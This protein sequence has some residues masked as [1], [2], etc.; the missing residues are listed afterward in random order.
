MP[1]IPGFSARPASQPD[2]H[3]LHY[4]GLRGLAGAII[5]VVA[6]ELSQVY[7][8]SNVPM[9]I[10]W[11][12]DGIATG[13]TLA[14]GPRILVPIG[15]AILLW[16]IFR[17]MSIAQ[18]LLGCGALMLAL[19]LTWSLVQRARRHD[20]GTGSPIAA[21]VRYHCLTVLPTAAILSL[22]GSWQFT[23]QPSSQSAPDIILVMAV[24]EILGILLF[25]RLSELSAQAAESLLA[26]ANKAKSWYRWRRQAARPAKRLAWLAGLFV[27]IFLLVHAAQPSADFWRMVAS[28]RYL[29]FILIAWA[30]YQGRPFFVHLMTVLS[31]II[32]IALTPEDI[33]DNAWLLPDLALLLGSVAFLGFMASSTMEH[34][35]KIEDSL[36]EAVRRD[37]LTGWLNEQGLVAALTRLPRSGYLVGIDLQTLRHTMELI[38]LLPT[39][40]IEKDLAA[41][42]QHDLRQATAFARP[43][44]GFFVIILPEHE[45]AY[46][47]LPRLGTLLNRRHRHGAYNVRIQASVSLLPLAGLPAQEAV[48]DMLATLMLSCQ[49]AAFRQEH[50]LTYDA[51]SLSE[52][53]DLDDMVRARRD[54]L[55]LLEEL[56]EALQHPPGGPKA[57]GLWLACQ[58]IHPVREHAHAPSVEILLRWTLQDGSLL[59]PDKFLPLAER[60]GLMQ[61]LDRWVVT[62]TISIVSAFPQALATL[63]KV[64]INLSGSSLSNP[65]LFDFVKRALDARGLRPSLFCFEITETASIVQRT[66]AI[67][68]LN[69]LRELGI[70]TSLDD[71]GTGLASFDYL[72]SLPLDYVKIDGRFIRDLPDD[73]VGLSIVNAICAVAQTMKLQ[74]IAEF[75]ETPEQRAVLDHCG[76]DQVQGYGIGKPVFL[77][78]YLKAAAGPA[79]I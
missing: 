26:G 78:D 23:L 9:S 21:M 7:S 42:I 72:I 50:A 37:P 13:L 36:H 75:V 17:G 68:L 38:G 55:A 34:R 33:R 57:P 14:Y 15:T 20:D 79:A 59:S 31:A 71:F 2:A 64:A 43:C 40:Q 3:T 39:H 77:I 25:A 69:R 47:C 6:A 27:L 11:P 46:A 30:A 48:A 54:Q 45:D 51:N 61:Q 67:K 22:I 8:F 28:A 53:T 70:R 52:Q 35:R 16:N 29:V 62:H 10:F 12:P 66:P 76:V 60:Y 49:R 58:C 65:Q 63:D 73:P 5:W 18:S 44:E 74:T 4:D 41:L 32:L 1:A 19:L 24:S 56:K